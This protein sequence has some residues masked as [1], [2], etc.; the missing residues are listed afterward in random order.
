MIIAV[1]DVEREVP[2]V[3]FQ[4]AIGRP[5]F[6]PLRR[7]PLLPVLQSPSRFFRDP[8]LDRRLNWN[9]GPWLG[10]GLRSMRAL[11]FGGKSF[12]DFWREKGKVL[13]F[14]QCVPP[15][16]SI[17]SRPFPLTPSLFW[18]AEL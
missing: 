7:L 16:C 11:G 5:E 15:T 14:N 6:S 13:G 17:T 9:L 3:G 4:L 8:H 1:H 18:I 12:S 10:A 2:S